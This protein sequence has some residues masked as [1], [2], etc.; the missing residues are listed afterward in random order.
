MGRPGRGHGCWPTFGQAHPCRHPDWGPGSL[1]QGQDTAKHHLHGCPMV[2]PVVCWHSEGSV[3]KSSASNCAGNR[4]EL[5]RWEKSVQ[6]ADQTGLCR[7]QDSAVCPWEVWAGCDELPTPSLR[8]QNRTGCAIMPV[9]VPDG[10]TPAIDLLCAAIPS[11]PL[12]SLTLSVHPTGYGHRT[13]TPGSF[14]GVNP[15][16]DVSGTSTQVTSHPST[17]C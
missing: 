3:A 9:W 6:S 16:T 5:E 8:G 15:K 11:V 10:M 1:C 14:H 12:G 17:L 7:L 4:G 13:T 2:S